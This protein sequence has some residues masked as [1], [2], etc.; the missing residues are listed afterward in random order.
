MNKELTLKR[1]IKSIKRIIGVYRKTTDGV[2]KVSLN[3]KYETCYG[4]CYVFDE[5]IGES[6][7]ALL[8]RKS[9]V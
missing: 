9:V 8:D 3:I 7:N 4:L 2:D 1:K 6:N 5:I